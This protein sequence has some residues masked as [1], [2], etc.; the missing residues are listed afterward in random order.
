MIPFWRTSM[1]VSLPVPEVL[2]RVWAANETGWPLSDRAR[3]WDG[4]QPVFARVA[5]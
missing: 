1:Q 5:S 3:C 2:A 4:P